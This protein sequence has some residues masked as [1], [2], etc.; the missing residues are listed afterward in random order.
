MQ[1]PMDHAVRGEVVVFPVVSF[2]ICQLSVA[3]KRSRRRENKAMSK[4]KVDHTSTRPWTPWTTPR[5]VQLLEEGK[6]GF[7][8][9][10]DGSSGI[11]LPTLAAPAFCED[12]NEAALNQGLARLGEVGHVCLSSAASTH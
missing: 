1:K 7:A 12:Q 11:V 8:V 9:L 5:P 3:I 4:D 10:N 6:A 2:N